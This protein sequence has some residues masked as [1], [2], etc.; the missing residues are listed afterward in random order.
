[1]DLDSVLPYVKAL[2]ADPDRQQDRVSDLRLANR[3]FVGSLVTTYVV[4]KG[5]GLQFVA[6]QDLTS[7]AVSVDELPQRAVHNFAALVAKQ[8]LRMP[9]Y[10][11]ITPVLF[12]GNF[13]VSVM[14][15]D[16]NWEWFEAQFG[17]PQIL[18]VAPARD[19][20]AFCPASSR[21]GRSQ[22]GD[23]IDRVWPTADHRLT[24]DFYRRV[25]GVWNLDQP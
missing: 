23:L 2:T 22:L 3:A 21:E 10:H 24:R 20:L 15:L 5:A 8:R 6:E 1:L 25:D 17:E 9:K 18:A 16:E 13:E 11:A 12:D 19:I 14:L 7:T 4:D